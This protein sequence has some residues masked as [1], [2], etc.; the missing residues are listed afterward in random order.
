MWGVTT[1]SDG[2]L[3]YNRGWERMPSNWYRMRG[4]Y[5]LVDLNLDLL[6]WVAKHPEIA[7]IGGNMGTVNSFAGVDLSDLTGGVLNAAKLLEGNN[8]VCFSLEIVK[9]F[10]PNSL[11]SLFTTLVKPLQIINDAVGPSLTSLA[12]PA[13]AELT[14]N[15]NDIVASLLGKY[16]GAKKS[17]FAL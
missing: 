9:A 3:K 16:P 14:A 5:N 6:T 13:M 10:A 2:T 11:S 8:L 17:G 1:Q 4:D 12:C 7:N 15:G